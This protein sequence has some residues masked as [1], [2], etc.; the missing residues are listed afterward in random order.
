MLCRVIRSGPFQR[1][2]MVNWAGSLLDRLPA[3][4]QF[5]AVLPKPARTVIKVI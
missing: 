5:K 1:K 2:F 4:S 3:H